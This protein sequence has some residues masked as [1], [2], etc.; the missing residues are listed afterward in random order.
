SSL[1]D[2]VVPLENRKTKRKRKIKIPRKIRHDDQISLDSTIETLLLPQKVSTSYQVAED[3]TSSN[4]QYH[5][6]LSNYGLGT[7]RGQIRRDDIIS[8][9]AKSA[10][11]FSTTTNRA[12]FE[13][14]PHRYTN[15][16]ISYHALNTFIATESNTKP[17]LRFAPPTTTTATTTTTTSTTT[18][19]TERSSTTI[20]STVEYEY[21]YEDEIDS[22]SEAAE[23]SNNNKE[24]EPD[25]VKKEV[26]S[27][28]NALS[29]TETNFKPSYREGFHPSRPGP[30]YSQPIR[31]NP[32]AT[33][34]YQKQN[35]FGVS[36]DFAGFSH[37]N[38]LLTYYK[39]FPTS[40]PTFKREIIPDHILANPQ[41]IYQNQW[42]TSGAVKKPLVDVTKEKVKYYETA[43][44]FDPYIDTVHSPQDNGE[45]V[46]ESRVSHGEN[47][48]SH[49][50]QSTKITTLH[51]QQLSSDY[52]A[53]ESS[54]SLLLL[55]PSG[56]RVPILSKITHDIR[57]MFSNMIHR[58]PQERPDTAEVDR[59]PQPPLM[60]R[61]RSG[62]HKMMGNQFGDRQFDGFDFIPLV[63]VLVG[64]GLLLA[65]LFPNALTN[66]AN[67]NVVLG[68]KDDLDGDLALLDHAI[69]Q[70]ESGILMISSLRRQDT[71]A[72][73]LACKLGGLAKENFD[74][75]EM[76]LGALKMVV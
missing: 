38:P 16:P 35:S 66:V 22:K 32:V 47:S 30:V 20:T 25:I 60:H 55:A 21:V 57:D 44:T 75:S 8:P 76:L 6:A 2:A 68:R 40:E 5:P 18:T 13:S 67:G 48:G 74:D 4:I 3:E 50:S 62:L 17:P 28:G 69:N 10:D 41:N 31:H 33:Q 59:A 9:A 65:A 63:V 64:A 36:V 24:P 1:A 12:P 19:N 71:C 52:S 53:T 46:T 26:K 51:Q 73:K 45:P 49:H 23:P 29:P 70:L 39:P 56:P 34:P 72:E 7:L 15:D 43:T 14:L 54:A 58:R 42:T 11:A 27:V 61:I 37:E